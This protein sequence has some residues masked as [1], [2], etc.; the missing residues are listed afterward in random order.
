MEIAADYEL[1]NLVTIDTSHHPPTFTLEHRDVAHEEGAEG[2][3]LSLGLV[4]KGTGGYQIPYTQD[5]ALDSATRLVDFMLEHLEALK[6][7]PF[8]VIENKA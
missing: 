2:V 7:Y 1:S 8:T 6:L 5:S 4:R 3:L